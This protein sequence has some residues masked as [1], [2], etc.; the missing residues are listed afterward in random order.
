MYA[1]SFDTVFLYSMVFEF[2]LSFWMGDENMIQ[3]IQQI[4]PNH[5]TGLQTTLKAMFQIFLFKKVCY[6]SVNVF[7]TCS[8][9]CSSL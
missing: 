1:Y 4:S 3:Q 6:F 5:K 7:I 2:F 8:R 9:E